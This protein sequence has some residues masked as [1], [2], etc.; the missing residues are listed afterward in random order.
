M[1]VQP[2]VLEVTFEVATI[3]EI[4]EL[5]DWDG[6][7]YRSP[8]NFIQVCAGGWQLEKNGR[9]YRFWKDPNFDA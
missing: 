2:T 1:G 7:D 5:Y 4:G 8:P 9:Q 6:E 3:S